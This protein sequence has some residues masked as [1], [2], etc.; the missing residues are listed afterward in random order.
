LLSSTQGSDLTGVARIFRVVRIVRL[1]RLFRIG[2]LLKV[3]AKSDSFEKLQ[4]TLSLSMSVVALLICVFC[5]SHVN[6][7]V[8]WGIG[9]SQSRL[10]WVTEAGIDQASIDVKYLVSLHWSLSQFTGG[11]D[12]FAPAN[13]LERAY[14]VVIWQVTFMAATLIVSILTSNLTQQHITNAG[15]K[16]QMTTLTKYLNQNDISSSL[17]LRMERSALHS[18]WGELSEDTVELLA[19]ISEPLKMEMHWE[20][21]SYVLSAHPYLGTLVQEVPHVMRKMCHHGTSTLILQEGDEVF[22][23][24]E[25]PTEPR[26][27][28]V[29]KGS[30][31]YSFD[32]DEDPVPIGARKWL[33]EGAL[34]TNWTYCGTLTAVDDAKL[35]MLD[36][37]T[38]Q[39]IAS[40]SRAFNN[41]SL[42]P[43][44]YAADFVQRLNEHSPPSD[45]PLEDQEKSKKSSVGRWSSIG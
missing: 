30:L 31:A 13:A 44:T 21:Y 32:P 28:I 34:W 36:A 11:M 27:Y 6:A 40:G 22:A 43:K 41:N 39:D 45:L 12:E 2:R 20:M 3:V 8:W 9:G 42:D 26:M 19:L 37:A 33:S 17:M 16:R 5:F 38:F 29:G 25:T 18:I 23:L 7:C 10:S 14:A 1:V 24:G 4:S 15:Q 35:V